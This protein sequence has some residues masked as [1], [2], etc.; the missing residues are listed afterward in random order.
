MCELADTQTSNVNKRTLG[1]SQLGDAA[2][3]LRCSGGVLGLPHAAAKQEVSTPSRLATHGALT[4]GACRSHQTSSRAPVRS[5][6]KPDAAGAD[7]YARACLRNSSASLYSSGCAPA[8]SGVHLGGATRRQ[9]TAR[10]SAQ[11]T[12]RALSAEKR[13]QGPSLGRD[14][15]DVVRVAVVQHLRARRP[16]SVS[17]AQTRRAQAASGT[18]PVLKPELDLLLGGVARP[19]LAHLAAAAA[20]LTVL[21]EKRSTAAPSAAL[22]R[23][24]ARARR[25]CAP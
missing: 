24:S 12:G 19:H 5:C 20:K 18:H 9:P 10:A 6:V 7:G 13:N 23:D 16:L 3:Q 14:H 1:G 15:A 25:A 21:Q 4:A 17:L 22:L 11:R 8:S 2:T